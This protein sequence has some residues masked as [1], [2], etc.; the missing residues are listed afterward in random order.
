MGSDALEFAVTDVETTG[1]FPGGHDRVIEIAVVRV[2]P[3]G[4]VLDE[5]CTLINPGRD[6]GPTHLHGI[7]AGD[8]LHAPTFGEVAGDLIALLSGAVFVAHNA[9]FD[10]RFLRAEMTRAGY[11]LP[12]FPA[13]CTM[14]LAHLADPCLG[15]RRLCDL[16]D[17]FDV[18]PGTSHAARDDAR[19]TAGLLAACL[20]DLDG[21]VGRV[22]HRIC[23]T[24]DIPPHAAWP[25]V[26]VSGLAFERGEAAGRRAQ[27][28]GFIADLVRRLPPS[29]D[30][31]ADVLE[32]QAVLDRVLEDRRITPDEGK[33]LEALAA[34][35]GLTRDEAR[36]ANEAYLLD[37]IRVALEDDVITEAEAADLADVQRLLGISDETFAKLERVAHEV[38]ER[39][40]LLA[41]DVPL[42]GQSV[43]FTGSMNCR[44]RG[45]RATRGLAL[46]LATE[47]G[48]VVKKNVSKKVGML[49]LADPDSMSG[50][51]RRARKLGVRL[52]AEPVFWRMIGI[53]VE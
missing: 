1:L 5:Y 51:A 23:A 53:A 37:M 49:V 27:S 46:Q 16:C 19:A 21:D 24:T 33:E 9:S 7:R 26:Q 28:E 8:V 52:V 30:A 48:L 22:L 12:E 35:I 31:H 3:D 32:Y 10:L 44:V 13:L 11:E 25:T 15:S 29:G 45:E 34:D 41:A 4:T 2:T 14:R 43:C 42:R 38:P 18:D 40:A 20:R 50:K 39:E 47:A 17:E 36:E 6:V